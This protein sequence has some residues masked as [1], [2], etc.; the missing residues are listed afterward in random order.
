MRHAWLSTAC[1]FALSRSSATTKRVAAVLRE[2]G[3]VYVQDAARLVREAQAAGLVPTTTTPGSSP[4]VS[5]GPSRSSPT[6]TGRG[7]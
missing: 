2:S 5:S 4:S 3:D 1:F 7:G 6:T